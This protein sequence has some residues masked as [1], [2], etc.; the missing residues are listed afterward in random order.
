MA[1]FPTKDWKDFPD[2]S[3]PITAAA[4]EDLEQRVTAIKFIGST[5]P[6]TTGWQ[7][8]DLWL[9]TSTET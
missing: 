9:D 5:E 1:R 2:T 8:D 4:L 3:T 6:D 7:V